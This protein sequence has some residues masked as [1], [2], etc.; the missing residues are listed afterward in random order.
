MAFAGFEGELNML[1]IPKYPA[2]RYHKSLD[3]ILVKNTEEDEEAAKNGYNL[4]NA[5]I[6][7]NTQLINW[8]WDLEDMSPRQLVVFAKDEYEV[9]LPIEA[10]QERLFKAICEL[11]KHAPQNQGRITLMAHTIKMNYDETL[12]QINRM[13]RGE[14]GGEMTV[15]RKEVY[16]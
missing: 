12:D 1:P 11:T 2:W 8:Y 3:P 7:A 5:P 14:L 4:A 9:D 15:E 10:G 13:N 6:T 16:L